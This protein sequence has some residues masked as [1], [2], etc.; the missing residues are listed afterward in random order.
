MTESKITIITFSSL[1]GG[2]GPQGA[3]RSLAG[4]LYMKG[5]LGKFVCTGY[6]VG[7]IPI[8][9]DFII[10]PP[11]KKILKFFFGLIN[12]FNRVFPF[13]ERRLKEELFDFFV[14]NI[15]SI[16]G[17]DD[18][19]LFLKPGFPKTVQKAVSLGQM[20]VGWASIHHPRFNYQQVLQEQHRYNLHSKSDYLDVRR[21]RN[22]GSFFERV[23][24]LLVQTEVARQNFKEYG[25]PEEN[26]YFVKEAYGVTSVKCTIPKT[27]SMDG[28]FRFGHLSHMDLIKGIGTLFEAWNEL[29]LKNIQLLIGGSYTGDILKIFHQLKPANT[30][31]SGSVDN[32]SAWFQKIDVFVSCSLSDARPNTILEAMANGVPVIVS[33]MCGLSELIEH[34]KNGFVYHYDN[35]EELSHLMSW[36]YENRNAVLEMG[37]AAKEKVAKLTQVD[38][39][40]KIIASIDDIVKKK[41][42]SK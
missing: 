30:I 35:K 29:D 5:R 12:R 3:A 34:G 38:F 9:E 10:V 26:I 18:I 13:K 16:A 14:S 11:G 19:L 36:C 17:G 27:L 40:E 6:D 7:D 25:I 39:S 2:G 22:V 4:A 24:T 21:V 42:E 23:N 31:F 20:T 8:P 33:N 15:S 32:V 28:S 37:K 1:K 41:Q